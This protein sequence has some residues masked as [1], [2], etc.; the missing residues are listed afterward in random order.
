M[1]K[2]LVINSKGGSGKTTV[3]TNLVCQLTRVGECAALC[4]DD[5]QASSTTWLSA[6]PTSLPGIH[7]VNPHQ[8]NITNRTRCWQQRVPVDTGYYVIDS[9]AGIDLPKLYDLI[10]GVDMI[11][12]PVLPSIIDIN[13]TSDFVRNLIKAGKVRAAPA[14]IG[15]IIN[16]SRERTLA[17]KKL[18]SFLDALE[19]PVIGKLNDSQSYVRAI[20]QGL[21]V[22]ELKKGYR[23]EQRAWQEILHWVLG[24]SPSACKTEPAV[25][26]VTDSAPVVERSATA[27]PETSTAIFETLHSLV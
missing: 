17:L 8:I 22:C 25:Q 23:R 9:P 5:P 21:G 7:G 11:L 2:I 19:L 12:I 6:R 10:R 18:E 27:L 15:I 14:R 1:K 20:D 4:D 26:R 13:A 3:A 24:R 16:R